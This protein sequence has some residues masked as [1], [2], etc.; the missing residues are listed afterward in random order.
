MSDGIWRLLLLLT[1]THTLRCLFICQNMVWCCQMMPAFNSNCSLR[2][3]LSFK[4]HWFQ[5]KGK[6][7][8][9]SSFYPK[10]KGNSNKRRIFMIS[11]GVLKTRTYP[12][13]RSYRSKH[14]KFFFENKN[15]GTLRKLERNAQTL[16]KSWCFFFNEIIWIHYFEDCH[17]P[18]LI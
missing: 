1:H 11:P 13:C 9:W 18:F 7:F 14:I 2:S 5:N 8:V 12:I 17:S 3:N 16:T 10:F 4:I 6:V 15:Y